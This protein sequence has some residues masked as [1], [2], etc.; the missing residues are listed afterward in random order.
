MPMSQINFL[1]IEYLQPP[2]TTQIVLQ[3]IE[4]IINYYP[5]ESLKYGKLEIT[6]D[7]VAMK[8][9][10]YILNKK[11]NSRTKKQKQ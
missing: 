4:K 2:L 7:T 1:V 10:T 9:K 8:K 3:D 6:E 11:K 5:M